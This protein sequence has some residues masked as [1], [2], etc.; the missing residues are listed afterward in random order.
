MTEALTSHFADYQETPVKETPA[1][2]PY[3]ADSDLGNITNKDLFQF[4][5]SAR[6]LLI[7]NGFVVVP[8]S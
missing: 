3:K 4:S 2:E 8:S 5:P 6:D 1:V 7:K